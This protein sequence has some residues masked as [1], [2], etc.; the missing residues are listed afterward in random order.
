M[1]GLVALAAQACGTAAAP[2]ARTIAE[3]PPVATPT[4]TLV[5][6]PAAALE[7]VPTH[8][9]PSPS[10]SD[11]DRV[12]RVRR[13]YEAL[14]DAA[15]A[16]AGIDPAAPPP[17]VPGSPPLDICHETWAGA[18]LAASCDPGYAANGDFVPTSGWV[19]TD[20]GVLVLSEDLLVD[21]DEHSDEYGCT[22]NSHVAWEPVLDR[23]PHVALA[24]LS[25]DTRR[26]AV[27]L[28][29]GG[30]VM[31]P[32]VDSSEAAVGLTPC[33]EVAFSDDGE[34]PSPRVERALDG[35]L[36]ATSICLSS[37]SAITDAAG[38]RR[39]AGREA[40]S[41]ALASL[42]APRRALGSRA[43]LPPC[44]MPS[45]AALAA[46]RSAVLRALAGEL[47]HA[48][49]GEDAEL[50]EWGNPMPPPLVRSEVRSGLA[51]AVAG[52]ADDEGTYLLEVVAPTISY[53]AVW[54]IAAEG[55]AELERLRA[56]DAGPDSI[57]SVSE[58]DLTGDGVAELLVSGSRYSGDPC[59]PVAPVATLASTEPAA[60]LDLGEVA[61]RASSFG[62]VILLRERDGRG[63][64]F[65]DE[66]PHA[67]EGALVGSEAWPELETLARYRVALAELRDALLARDPA[68][69]RCEPDATRRWAAAALAALAQ[70]DVPAPEATRLVEAATTCRSP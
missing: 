68:V 53:A 36:S 16:A 63:G 24:I 27:S 58:A 46:G 57:D 15:L 28:G 70:L 33:G 62:G 20:G 45:R 39:D 10:P 64:L 5:A 43:S 22:D 21:V 41:T 47:V 61:D 30:T 52:C 59:G 31:M 18:A 4:E 3:A 14:R 6:V 32:L 9:E 23:D 50:D 67:W 40:V 2:S 13:S 38:A 49:D 55:A 19:V 44:T 34:V 17:V 51:R 1:A 8:E 54:R 29:P 42:A 60:T 26:A 35:S 12:A 48:D 56:G 69:L 7:D 11:P 25:G 37:L 66:I 65:F